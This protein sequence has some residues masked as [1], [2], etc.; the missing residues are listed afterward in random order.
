MSPQTLDR[1]LLE[2]ECDDDLHICMRP[3]PFGAPEGLSLTIAVFGDSTAQPKA[4]AFRA[5]Q[6]MI[7]EGFHLESFPRTLG[8]SGSA[9]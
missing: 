8:S 5:V 7:S 6:C 9:W 4:S 2:Q 1:P 3:L